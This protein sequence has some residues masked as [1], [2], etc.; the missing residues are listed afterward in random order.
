MKKLFYGLSIVAFIAIMVTCIFVFTKDDEKPNA[1]V[2][3]GVP[4]ANV[5]LEVTDVP[6]GTETPEI[7]ITEAPVVTEVPAMTVTPMPSVT[8]APV[9]TLVPE[10]TE[11]PE[12]EATATPIPTEVPEP[13]VTP[14]PT[15]EPKATATPT[16]AASATPK[17]TKAPKA[18]VTPKP[19]AKSASVKMSK[20]ARANYD[21]I[22]AIDPEIA[23]KYQKDIAK[24]DWYDATSEHALDDLN[25]HYVLS[26]DGS[27]IVV[28]D[29]IVLTSVK[30]MEKNFAVVDW[31]DNEVT[32]KKGDLVYLNGAE[33]SCWWVT[34]IKNGIVVLSLTT[35]KGCDVFISNRDL[36]Y[37]NTEYLREV[38][39]KKFFN[40]HIAELRENPAFK[41]S[42]VWE[43]TSYHWRKFG[44]NDI[45]YN[46]KYGVEKHTGYS[47]VE[48]GRTA[49][50]AAGDIAGGSTKE[51]TNVIGDKWILPKDSEWFK[52]V[53]GDYDV[54]AS[55]SYYSS[56]RET[57]FVVTAESD[58][59]VIL[60]LYHF[61]SEA[62]ATKDPFVQ[63]LCRPFS[64]FSDDYILGWSSRNQESP[65]LVTKLGRLGLGY[66]YEDYNYET[67][68]KLYN[69]YENSGS[70]SS[71]LDWYNKTIVEPCDEQNKNNNDYSDEWYTP[72]FTKP[73]YLG[74]FIKEFLAT[75]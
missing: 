38:L 52:S 64:E 47:A 6:A 74:K 39:D 69:V 5:T 43:E 8:E 49:D 2:A 61:E 1:S 45:I 60:E 28:G 70:S 4:T 72:D 17:A 20:Q 32:L 19:T 21:A 16:V 14:V 66:L 25:L 31:K 42:W 59:H 65:Y 3:T 55:G 67:F 29:S 62:D 7:K 11:A 57:M 36:T 75:Q 41:Y 22:A 15:E 35:E 23:E 48:D 58:T 53:E 50:W 24:I 26:D 40:E 68:K 13:T 9:A 73:L 51:R 30:T 56:T 44:F 37:V 18:T 46:G 63:F 10:V 34:E 54:L 27:G 12:I 33:H 71:W